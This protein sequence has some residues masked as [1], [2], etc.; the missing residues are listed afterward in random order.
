MSYTLPSRLNSAT[1]SWKS[2]WWAVAILYCLSGL[3]SLAYEVLWAR[4]LSMQFGV[5]IFG[6]VL[7]VAAFMIGLGL[8]SL[9]GV[10]WAKICNKPLAWFAMLE[11]AIALYSLLL[12]SLIQ[13]ISGWMEGIAGKL[14]LA[15]WY[16]LQGSE[17]L[18][19][20]VIPAFAMGMSFALV[21]KAV[22]RTPLSLG[23]LYGLNTIGGAAGALFPL[24]SL[25]AL[26][27]T[28]SVRAIA[29]LGLAVGAAA[30]A[31]SYFIRSGVGAHHPTENNRQP[32]PP[33]TPLIIYAGIGA[34]SI[35]LEVGWIRLY[36]MIMLRTE[37]VLGVIL[38]V[39]LLG[40]ALGSMV[41]PRVHKYWLTVLMP[42]VAGGGVLV[43][44]WL[45]P[46]AS[47]WVEQIQFQSFSGAVWTQ[48]LLLGIFTLPVT[49]ALGAWLPLLASRYASAEASGVWLYG[50]NCLG[51]ATGAV[52]AC[53]VFIPLF[54][55]TATVAIA[56]L[57]IAALGLSWVKS[58]W[59][60][61]AFAV[62]LMA[63]WPLRN[64]P[65]VHKLLPQIEANSRDLYLYEDAI[66]MTHV[67]RQQD[68]QRVLLSDLQRMDASTDPG[69]VEIQKDQARL[70]LLLHPAPHSVLFLG[71]GTGISMA[72]SLPFPDLQ[73][74]AVELSQGSIIAARSWFAP[75][76]GNIMD[77][78]KVQRDDARHFLSTTRRNY[79]VIIGDLFHPDLAGMGS[80]LSVQQFKRAKNHLNADGIFVQ[81]LALNQF[82]I[83]SLEVV[84]RSFKQVFPDAQL[85]MDGMHLAMVGPRQG[86]LGASA[87]LGNMHRLT[88]QE[89]GQATG[90][91]GTW[92]WLGRYWG[93]ISE[94]V[95]PV[96]DEW[97]PYIEFSLP[98]A[99][100]DGSVNLPSLMS[101]LLQQHPDTDAAMKILGI[102]N[103]DRESFGRAYIATELTVRAWVASIQGDAAKEGNLIWLAYQANPQDHWIADAL[104]DNMLQ[105]I[106]QASQ[107]GLS[108]REALQ[109]I[110][111]VSP[112]FVGALRA[113]WHLEQSAGNGEEAEH[114]RLRLLAVSPLDGEAGNTH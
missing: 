64:M 114:Y 24:W 57:A 41:L 8:G 21:L 71:L 52:A 40:I 12:P 70:A 3:T 76:N 99:R 59:V 104:A 80:L 67:V 79:D 34:G 90:G 25:S 91:E 74:S 75:V 20:L 56:G 28:V 93:P 2:W 60:W 7:T 16:L 47:A 31:L 113:L 27:W 35:M 106:S 92:T 86:F 29:L 45:L 38:A 9:A 49:L 77:Q 108:E 87:L 63:A 68:G 17:A 48:A 65:P 6:V 13:A 39:F 102:G 100:Y 46:A 82:D 62:M 51:G 69:A 55:S 30:L 73:R 43:S 23:K 103:A 84:L 105:S 81:W 97:V 33:L 54:G 107:H 89:Q 94:S 109:R 4:M 78:A 26:G 19:L 5:S 11:M 61:L 36:G 44:L 88:A 58:R 14:T 53:L 83:Q 37:Y 50:A 18:C 111:K 96:Q 110:L 32:R 95:G 1:S 66:S 85:F 101:W 10:K 72:G 42:L 98:R 22:E 15:Q 112:N